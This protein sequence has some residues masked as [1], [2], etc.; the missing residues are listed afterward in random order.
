MRL[1][2]LFRQ[3]Y[4]AAFGVKP[5]FSVAYLSDAELVDRTHGIRE[6]HAAG[7]FASQPDRVAA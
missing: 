5:A 3:A 1:E 7:R 2:R 4:K 6:A